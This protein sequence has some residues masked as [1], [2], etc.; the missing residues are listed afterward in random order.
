MNGQ[1]TFDGLG[2]VV[3]GEADNACFALGIGADQLD[4]GFVGLDRL[5]NEEL[6]FGELGV[7]DPEGGDALGFHLLAVEFHFADFAHAVNA[8]AAIGELHSGAVGIDAHDVAEGL[9]G[10]GADVAGDRFEDE[11]AVLLL[12]GTGDGEGDFSRSLF[13]FEVGDATESLAGLGHDF[14]GGDGFEEIF[15]GFLGLDQVAADFV[16]FATVELDPGVF[17]LQFPELLQGGGGRSVVT[18]IEGLGHVV[19]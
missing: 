1:S 13:L 5:D 17:G 15:V 18:A 12:V 2:D 16:E 9:A 11:D 14:W 6:G 3:P 19:E 7:G 10:L 8:P 4:G